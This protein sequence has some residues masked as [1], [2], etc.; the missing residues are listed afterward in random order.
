MSCRV[1]SMLTLTEHK[2]NPLMAPL[3]TKLTYLNSKTAS[4]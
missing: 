3:Y 4:I 1:L 2:S